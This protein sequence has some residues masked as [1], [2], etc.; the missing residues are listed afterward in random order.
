V[1]PLCIDLCCGKK[2]GWAK[3]FIAEDYRVIGFDIDDCPEYP[4]EFHRVDV[5]QFPTWAIKLAADATVIVASPPCEEFTRHHLPW[6]RRHNPPHP[7]LSIIQA[8]KHIA[9]EAGRPLVMEN[10]IAAQKWI[11][12]AK[13]HYGTRYLWG[14][15]PPML[16]KAEPSRKEH[17]SSTA[18]SKRAEIPFELA[19]WIAHVY[20]PNGDEKRLSF[21]SPRNSLILERETGI[22]PATNSLEG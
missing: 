18:R 9:S 7:D 11:G 3:G 13:A 19:R 1:K 22:E 2:G 5:R 16:P 4:A 12:T 6:L 21:P 17:M 20:K 10:V 15:V 8:C 14:D